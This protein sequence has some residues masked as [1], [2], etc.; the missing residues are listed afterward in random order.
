MVQKFILKTVIP[1]SFRGAAC[2]FLAR[3]SGISKGS[4]KDAMDKGA[5]WIRR[6]N[7]GRLGRLRG[8]TAH[9]S[10]G[11]LV[12]L[13]Y[14]ERLLACVPPQARCICKGGRYSA[15]HKP[16][17]LL[18]QGTMFGDHCSL[19][20]QAELFC[21]T[22][23]K[24]FPVHRLDRE[25]AGIML[26]AHDADA[27]AKLSAVFREKKIIKKYMAVLA[28]DL[29]TEG[30]KGVIRLPLDG[31]PAVTEFEVN[32]FDAEK[33]TTTVN[34]VIHTGR[35]HQIRRHFDMIGFPVMGDPKYGRGNK[36]T[37]G[38]QL[39]ALSLRFRCP[40]SGGEVEFNSGDI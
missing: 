3:E 4:I 17:G 36:N 23:R 18:A 16:A 10:G 32:S 13:Y 33:N 9:I 24:I 7:R 38:M 11:D 31:K 37:E 30:M 21:G 40:L 34:V 19:L 29:R 14:D 8:A 39:F 27:A 6:R 12:E 5:V 28:G 20:R 1:P 26:V 2:D 22:S 15:W 35:L 25:T